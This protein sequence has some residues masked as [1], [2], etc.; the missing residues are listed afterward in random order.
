MLFLIRLLRGMAAAAAMMLAMQG[1]AVG[2]PIDD[3]APASPNQPADQAG[4]NPATSDE[5]SPKAE[6]ANEAAKTLEEARRAFA[7]REF[8]RSRELLIVAVAQQPTL[9]PSKLILAEMYLDANLGDASRELLERVALEDPRHPELFRLLGRL[10]L[11]ENRW[12]EAVMHFEKAIELAATARW[13]VPQR[14]H[15]V[16]SCQESLATAS[17][18]RGDWPAAV[19]ILRTIV[20]LQPANAVLRDRWAAA[21]FESGRKDKAYEQFKIAQLQNP[22]LS[23]PEVSMGVMYVSHRDFETADGWFAKAFKKYPASPQIRYQI[24][25]ALI[26]QDRAKEAALHAGKAA[27]MGMTSIE[28]MMVRGYAARQLKQWQAAADLFRAALAKRP[29][30]PAISNQLA[31]CL[32]EQDEPA[33][34][35]EAMQIADAL[36]RREP[37]SLQ[38][39]ATLGWIYYRLGKTAEASTPLQRVAL[40][41]GAGPESLYLAGR[42]F[43]AEGHHDLAEHVAQRLA[44]RLAFSG[45][46]VL[47]PDARDW[48]HEILSES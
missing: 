6:P 26:V 9:P 35:N 22:Q 24:S 21:L 3:V 39:Q 31:L 19:E 7:Q 25:L 29:N 33:A 30:D 42:F 37:N 40:H 18:R 46:F 48:V 17:E 45:I 14:N 34:R 32:I 4:G 23:P 38:A 28:L 8:A 16:L 2:A 36:L 5:G 43:S 27:E 11:M 10:A 12:T 47:R 20:A 15:F 41:K 44:G 1:F 13:E